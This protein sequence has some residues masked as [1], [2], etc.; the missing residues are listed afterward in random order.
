MSILMN[1]WYLMETR[2]T[3]A[4]IDPSFCHF[5]PQKVLRVRAFLCKRRVLKKLSKKQK[6]LL[7]KRWKADIIIKL[8]HGAVLRRRSGWTLKIKQ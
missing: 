6:K 1:S 4:F 5:R 2:C 7:T 3:Y 8:T